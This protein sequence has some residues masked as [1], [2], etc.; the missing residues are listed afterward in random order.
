MSVGK[1]RFIRFLVI[2]WGHLPLE[3]VIG[4]KAIEVGGRRMAHEEGA[5]NKNPSQ[6]P[7]LGS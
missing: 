3:D 6:V 2:E 7:I 1:F 5:V 4:K